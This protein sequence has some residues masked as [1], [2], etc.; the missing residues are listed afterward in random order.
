MLQK[1]H[2]EIVKNCVKLSDMV[3]L[4]DMLT[5]YANRLNLG[6]LFTYKH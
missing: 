3:T 5:L 6:F 4:R 2:K 1:G